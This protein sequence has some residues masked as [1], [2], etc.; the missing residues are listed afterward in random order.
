MR[1]EV[2]KY[3]FDIRLAAGRVQEFTAGK[4]FEDYATDVLLRSAVE[5]Q[6]G[7]VGEALSQLDKVDPESAVRITDRKRII[8]F[9]NILVHAYAQIDDR[10]VWGVIRSNLSTLAA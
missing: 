5:R 7:I 9:R 1:L 10:V 8:A 3:L 6:C 4:T 2:K